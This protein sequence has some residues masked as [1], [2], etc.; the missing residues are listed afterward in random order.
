[1]YRASAN[2][3]SYIGLSMIGTGGGGEKLGDTTRTNMGL[4]KK[5]KADL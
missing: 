2:W 4:E 5:I 1:M 3:V